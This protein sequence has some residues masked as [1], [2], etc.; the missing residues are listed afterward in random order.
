MKGERILFVLS[1]PDGGV[2]HVATW[3]LELGRRRVVEFCAALI[4]ATGPIRVGSMHYPGWM[5]KSL[6]VEDPAT[7]MAMGFGPSEI[8]ADLA[9]NIVDLRVSAPGLGFRTQFIADADAV[10][11]AVDLSGEQGPG[12]PYRTQLGAVTGLC[13]IAGLQ[14]E[15][16]GLGAWETSAID[17]CVAPESSAG[18]GG[19][20]GERSEVGGF[21]RAWVLL[22][23]VSLAFP[24]GPPGRGGPFGFGGP[25]RRVMYKPGLETRVSGSAREGLTIEIDNGEASRSWCV[26]AEDMLETPLVGYLPFSWRLER[27]WWSRRLPKWQ[28]H[29]RA[30]SLP[31]G[32]RVGVQEEWRLR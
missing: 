19:A 3:I 9:K 28:L 22:D 25:E 14:G 4:P 1:L 30:L 24:I 27:W 5:L 7:G 13:G 6:P 18:Q 31:D 16:A 23:D 8:V 15:V 20:P 29:L 12:L 17:L 26:H 10:D 2:A 21:S 32:T 11:G